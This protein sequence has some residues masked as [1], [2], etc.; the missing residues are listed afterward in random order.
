MSFTRYWLLCLR[1]Y[2]NYKYQG[3]LSKA[4]SYISVLSQYSEE[5]IWDLWESGL[6]LEAG[7]L[8]HR[9]SVL[10]IEEWLIPILV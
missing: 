3:S 5:Q 8:G 2:F 6:S 4:P 9:D 7:L 10:L 1:D